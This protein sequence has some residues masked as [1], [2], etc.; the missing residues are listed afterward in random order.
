MNLGS[1]IFERDQQRL[2]APLTPQRLSK[3]AAL[4]RHQA[5]SSA[6]SPILSPIN[7]QQTGERSMVRVA[8]ESWSG[9]IEPD[10]VLTT[11]ADGDFSDSRSGVLTDELDLS[12]AMAK[13]SGLWLII[14]R[15]FSAKHLVQE[16]FVV[17]IY[18]ESPQAVTVG[19]WRCLDD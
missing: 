4:V 10:K 16:A 5:S 8:I 9:R 18:V 2:A 19:D 1:V 14:E 15:M 11:S 7:Q 3:F 17:D 6:P 13:D 12:P